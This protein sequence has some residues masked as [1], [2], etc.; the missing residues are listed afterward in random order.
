MWGS[1]RA[2]IRTA[3]GLI[4]LSS[5][6]MVFDPIR[7]VDAGDSSSGAFALLTTQSLQHAVESGSRAMVIR[8]LEELDGSSISYAPCFW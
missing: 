8:A 1:V 6:S 5:P 4:W 7:Q 3:L 2:E